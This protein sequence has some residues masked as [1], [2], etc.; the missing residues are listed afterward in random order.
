MLSSHGAEGDRIP[1][2]INE[3]VGRDLFIPEDFDSIAIKFAQ[4]GESVSRLITEL[5]EP[6]SNFEDCV[7]WLGE[8]RVKEEVLKLCAGGKVA[9]NLRGLELLQLEPGEGFEE[10][11][12][13][14]K[15]KLGRGRELDSTNLMTPQTFV[16]ATGSLPKNSDVSANFGQNP[17]ASQSESETK[18]SIF[19]NPSDNKNFRKFNSD[20]P[21]SPLNLLGKT[22]SWGIGP[23]TSLKEIRIS[24]SSMTGA[25]IQRLLKNL[26]DGVTYSLELDKEE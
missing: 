5:K 19:N 20:F 4:K 13:R 16:G 15:G 22:E 18:F 2:A 14:L 11:W 26:P 7:P 8:E 10:A 12:R 25:Q 3:I 24:I 6:R 21:T 23:A 9:I 17:T 1:N